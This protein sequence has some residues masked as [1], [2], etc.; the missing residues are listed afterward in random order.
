MLVEIFK[1]VV[2]HTQTRKTCKIFSN[3]SMRSGLLLSEKELNQQ[4][5]RTRFAT[6]CHLAQTQFLELKA[7]AALNLSSVSCLRL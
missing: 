5:N 7:K 4:R 6:L 1:I 2:E 3:S